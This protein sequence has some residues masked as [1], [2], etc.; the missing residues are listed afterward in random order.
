MQDEGGGPPLEV[1][2]RLMV[3]PEKEAAEKASREKAEALA[4]KVTSAA[5]AA[6]RVRRVVAIVGL[7]LGALVMGI[8]FLGH[9]HGLGDYVLSADECWSRRML[10]SE[11][12]RLLSVGGMCTK[13]CVDDAACGPRFRCHGGDCV[14]LA[15]KKLGEDCS[16]PWNCD[17]YLCITQTPLL[18]GL[19]GDGAQAGD[20]AH[21]SSYC[22]KSCNSDPS[23]CPSGFLCDHVSGIDVCVKD[24]NG[25]GDILQRLG[26]AQGPAT[27]ASPAP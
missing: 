7:A 18:G 27:L 6:Q 5:A 13:D 2:P 9:S 20:A 19:L 3:E 23:S 22:S 24:A 17:D 12:G 25:L 16:A 15:T 10:R 14:P 1:K 4:A 21:A 11:G 26:E 8:R